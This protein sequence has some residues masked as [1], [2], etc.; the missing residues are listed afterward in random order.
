MKIFLCDRL[1]KI[2]FSENIKHVRTQHGYDVN[3]IFF[4][5]LKNIN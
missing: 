2:F 1:I 5:R 4:M 3:Y